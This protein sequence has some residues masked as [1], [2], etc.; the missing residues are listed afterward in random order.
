MRQLERTLNKKM[1]LAEAK[2]EQ[3]KAD[4]VTS[5]WS[6]SRSH[7]LGA[8]ESRAMSSH[9]KGEGNSLREDEDE[10]EQVQI[11]MRN[12]ETKFLRAKDQRD[13]LM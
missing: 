4:M 1:S 12:L 5:R 8:N 10:T 11:Y 2:R 3:M 7:I 9:A 13:K 6:L